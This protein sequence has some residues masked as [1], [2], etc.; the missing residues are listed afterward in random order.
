MS[1]GHK[2]RV[3]VPASQG[4]S[5]SVPGSQVLGSQVSDLGVLDPRSQVLRSRLESLRGG[6]LL[7]T[8]KFPEIAGTCFI[9]L[10][11]M[12]G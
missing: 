5:L 4:P 2:P 3:P 11:R 7:F 9:D 10:E 6:S 8:T 12:E 1:Q